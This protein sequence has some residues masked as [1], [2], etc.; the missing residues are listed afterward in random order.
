MMGMAEGAAGHVLVVDDERT[1]RAELL[2]LLEDEG[3]DVLA[4]ANGREALDHLKAGARPAV[5]LLDVVMPVMDGAQFRRAL[6]DDPRLAAIPV[7][8]ITALPEEAESLVPGDDVQA[9]AKPFSVDDLAA[10]VA[11]YCPQRRW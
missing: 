4:F 5:I 9:M 10:L 2:E 6:L 3:Y 11:E 7:V 1:V 8:V